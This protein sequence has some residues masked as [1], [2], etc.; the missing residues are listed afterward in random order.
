MQSTTVELDGR[1]A[2]RTAHFAAKDAVAS[3]DGRVS[4]AQA[5]LD[6]IKDQVA[7]LRRGEKPRRFRCVKSE[8]LTNL[9]GAGVRF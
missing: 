6:S 8:P 9:N 5:E 4:A 2:E 7:A 3:V 1:I